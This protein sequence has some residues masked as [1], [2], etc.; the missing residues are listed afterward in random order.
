M[1]HPCDNDLVRIGTH[2]SCDLPQNGQALVGF[3][4][5]VL[6]WNWT[7]LPGVGSL[8]KDGVADEGDLVRAAEI[9]QVI[10]DTDLRAEIGA[11]PRL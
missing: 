5:G 1:S 2:F 6:G 10:V 4:T 11:V 7:I 3:W 9:L 8:E